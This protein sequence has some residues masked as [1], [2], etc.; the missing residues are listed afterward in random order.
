M[1]SSGQAGPPRAQFSGSDRTRMRSRSKPSTRKASK[2]ASDASMHRRFGFRVE[3]YVSHVNFFPLR[4]HLGTTQRR[5]PS[6]VRCIRDVDGSSLRLSGRSSSSMSSMSEASARLRSAVR[7][8]C[9]GRRRHHV[10]SSSAAVRAPVASEAGSDLSCRHIL[11]FFG[12]HSRGGG[13]RGSCF[14][15]E[16]KPGKVSAEM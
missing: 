2:R 1:L 13:V 11:W 12:P 9:Y 15:T 7:S 16:P 14:A 6:A 3:K 4:L 10:E 5:T 8:S